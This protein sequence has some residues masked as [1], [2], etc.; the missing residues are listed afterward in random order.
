MVRSPADEPG[1]EEVGAEAGAMPAKLGPALT[2]CRPNW[3]AGL[4]IATPAV[5]SLVSSLL[6]GV[7]SVPPAAVDLGQNG[8]IFIHSLIHQLAPT[9]ACGARFGDCGV[10][11]SAWSPN[12]R[13]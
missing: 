13:M 4:S 6:L 11:Q 12:M 7:P 2:G 8:V 1:E 10:Q 3:E 5:A 9:D